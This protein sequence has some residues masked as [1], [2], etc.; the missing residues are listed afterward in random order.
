M[1]LDLAQ[2]GL[3][4]VERSAELLALL[5]GA[6]EDGLVPEPLVRHRQPVELDLEQRG[7][8]RGRGP[9]ARDE[10]GEAQREPLGPI[11]DRCGTPG[12]PALLEQPEQQQ[13]I[14]P[15]REVPA[16]ALMP[17]ER[18]VQRGDLVGVAEGVGGA[19]VEPEAL[20]ATEPLLCLMVG[21]VEVV[22]SLQVGHQRG[23][24]LTWQMA[25]SPSR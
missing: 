19:G 20:G 7:V 8:A 13:P 16:L 12:V 6:V 9:N 21:D 17:G 22:L 14:V 10:L 11:P 3:L 24:P 1:G 4:R 5:S 23:I 18:G 15:G 2:L 25:M